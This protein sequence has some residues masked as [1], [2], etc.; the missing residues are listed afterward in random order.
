[1]P[2]AAMLRLDAQILQ[3]DARATKER[4]EVMEEE[5]EP[6]FLFALER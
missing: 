3:I 4:R 2:L 5:G 1:M 6:H